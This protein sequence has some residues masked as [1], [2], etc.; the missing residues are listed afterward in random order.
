MIELGSQKDSLADVSKTD[1]DLFARA[2]AIHSRIL[3]IDTHVD[4]PPDFGTESYDPREAKERRGQ[5]DLVGMEHGGLD[6]VFFVVYVGQGERNV[7]GYAQAIADAFT[8]F[9][10][11]RRM[12]DVQYPDTI[13]LART[14]A[15]V[16]RIHGEGRLAALIGIEN[17]HALGRNL[18]M[19][20]T[21]YDYGARYLG[22]L[23]NG[24]ND[25]GDSAVPYPRLKDPAAE[26]GGLTKLG[27]AVVQRANQLGV[28]VDISHA[29]MTTALD[30]IRVS[31]AP[32]IASHS[33]V[34]GVYD[35][36][37]NLSDE[38]LAAIKANGGVAQMVAFDSYL[39]PV[40]HERQ[41][42]LR[43]LRTEMG[44]KSFAELQRLSPAKRDAHHTRR[45]EINLKWPKASVRDFADHIDY[46]V[47]FT[48][49]DH[50]GI[51]SDFNG[52]GG[53]TGW[54]TARD[55]L[56]VTVELV[57]RN[58]SETQ[59][60]QLWGGNLLRVMETVETAAQRP[61]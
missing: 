6:A 38:A 11:I 46:A 4:I 37:R 25:L 48:G 17:G 5:I 42:A 50:V 13:V 8:K 32:V 44:V 15:D 21:Y 39:R 56:N 24:H 28:M 33:S 45:E 29:A 18:D 34:Q 54:N 9:A 19:L 23:H 52:G 60:A 51:A 57:R 27:R 1:S 55:T 30:T 61:E 7:V 3:S 10:A 2:A 20:Q 12:T 40:S 41:S 36:P 43:A 49:I 58:Y 14:A 31:R 26:H 35:H 16:R 53:I 22:L 47:K 59:I